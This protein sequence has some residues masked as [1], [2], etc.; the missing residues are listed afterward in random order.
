MGNVLGALPRCAVAAADRPRA[1]AP[2]PEVRI[3]PSQA[4][5]FVA[6]EPPPDFVRVMD[7]QQEQLARSLGEG[8]VIHGVA[9]S[10]K[11]L[12]LGYRAE[13][14]GAGMR[15][16]DPDPLLQRVAGA[17]HRQHDAPRGWR[18][19]CMCITSISGAARSQLVAYHVDLPKPAE[20]KNAFFAEVVDRVIRAVERGQIP[21]AQYDAVL[22]DEGHDFR[23][24]WL[25]L[26]ADGRSEDQQ[27][28]GALRRRAVDLRR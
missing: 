1:L 15:Q 24:E 23:P 10:G 8:I 3:Q 6:D 20:D 11:T 2:V 4:D 5:L 28:A 16:A 7:L 19:R 13:A 17:P 14:S 26:V 9:G 21:A 12:I 25:K 18:R 27:P 22:I